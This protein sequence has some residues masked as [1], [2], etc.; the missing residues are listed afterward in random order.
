MGTQFNVVVTS[1]L[2]STTIVRSIVPM[3]NPL[4]PVGSFFADMA[5]ALRDWYATML[6]WLVDLITT[7]SVP[8]PEVLVND[9]FSLALGGTYGLARVLVALVAVAVAFVIMLSPTARHGVKMQRVIVS[10]VMTILLGFAFYPVYGLLYNVSKAGVAGVKAL[11]MTD[12]ETIYDAVM[13]LFGSL[14]IVDAINTIIATGISGVF[15]IFLAGTAVAL[16]VTTI[17]VMIGY[18]LAIAIRPLGG[19]GN[20]AF[21]L[22]NAAILTTLLSP[23]IMAFLFMAP[24]FIQKFIPGVAVVASPF[25]AL[26]GSLG[27]LLTPYV[28]FFMAFNKSSEVFGRLD[29]ASGQ[30][31]I[32]KM[33]PVSV[34]EMKNDIDQTNHMNT[35]TTLIADAMG[36]SLLYGNGSDFFDDVLK[37]GVDIGATAATAAG[38]PYIGV[39][40][41]AAGGVYSNVRNSQK[42]SADGE[43]SIGGGEDEIVLDV[44]EDDTGGEFYGER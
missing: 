1:S 11:V 7:V 39:G 23:T 34:D 26:V 18:P 2:V 27:A 19:F 30:F 29:D 12:G 8:P 6:V 28:I 5:A 17:V 13:R 44:T 37:K 32:G 43:E 40:L 22:F 41:K 42:A 31:D 4:D 3:W 21:N 9:F 16:F 33:P 20:T 25:F 36:D 14:N 35:T 15:G 38:H 10:V 24:L